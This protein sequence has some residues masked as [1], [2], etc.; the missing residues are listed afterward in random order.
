MEELNHEAVSRYELIVA[1]RDQGTPPKRD[2]ARVIVNALD[3]NDHAPEFVE[4]NFEGL[5][6]S[7][8][9]VGTSVM[10]MIGMDRDQGINAEILYSILSGWE[11]L[12]LAV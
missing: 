9:P 12:L 6:F 11:H 1:V 2:R 4:E 10:Q 3:H 7:A 8:A 5:V